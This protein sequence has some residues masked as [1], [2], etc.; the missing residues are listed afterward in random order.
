[1]D[2]SETEQMS[3]VLRYY[4][5]GSVHE[6]FVVFK[7]AEV[8]DAEGHTNTI[9]HCLQSFGLNYKD[10]RVGQ[11][12]D[13]AAVMS[14]QR[15]GVATRLKALVKHALYVHC[16]AHRLNLVLVD[17]AKSVPE[18]SHFFALLEKLYVFISGS[19]V[20]AK[21]KELQIEMYPGEAPRELPR[22]G[23][24]R[25]ACRYFTCCNVRDRLPAILQLL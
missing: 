12:Y 21:W 16:H 25:W 18:A 23:D 10:Y 4:G 20:Y 13:G 1:K 24:T 7:A 2:V 3:L 5:D 17:T 22:L 14:G 9:L 8:L 19:Y 11:A 15:S 6:R